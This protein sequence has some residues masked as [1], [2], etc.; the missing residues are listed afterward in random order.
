M[1][2]LIFTII[3]LIISVACSFACLNRDTMKLKN[4]LELFSD[5]QN[6]VTNG[7]YLISFHKIES[8]LKSL[9]AFIKK[10]KIL[11]N[12]KIKDSFIFLTI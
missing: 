12:C 2:K 1:N 7:H 4:N 9:I 11:I 3:L 5:L 6:G 10:L 8:V